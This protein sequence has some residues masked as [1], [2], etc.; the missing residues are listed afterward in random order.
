MTPQLFL[1]PSSDAPKRFKGNKQ[2][3]V[4]RLNI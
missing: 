1:D 2:E 4:Y 3:I